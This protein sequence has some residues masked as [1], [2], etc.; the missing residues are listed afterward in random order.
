MTEYCWNTTEMFPMKMPCKIVRFVNCQGLN[1][2]DTLLASGAVSS[3]AA[4]VPFFYLLCNSGGKVTSAFA[5]LNE[6][7]Y[8][9]SWYACPVKYQLYLLTMI[10]MAK[11]PKYLGGFALLRCSRETFKQVILAI[12]TFVEAFCQLCGLFLLSSSIFAL[13]LPIRLD[14]EQK[15][16]FLHDAPRFRLGRL[17]SN[18]IWYGLFWLRKNCKKKLINSNASAGILKTPKYAHSTVSPTSSNK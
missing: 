11:K 8:N 16:F 9:L 14:H 6:S 1:T 3:M 10:T 17:F 5:E 15:L 13:S 18:V 4:F 12:N 7:I 2:G